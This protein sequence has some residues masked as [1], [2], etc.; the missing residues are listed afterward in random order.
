[1]FGTA[2]TQF[3]INH[4]GHYVR[5][6]SRAELAKY[7]FP[8]ESASRKILACYFAIPGGIGLGSFIAAI[9][10]PF[11]LYRCP[12]LLNRPAKCGSCSSTSTA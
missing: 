10:L 4:E 8:D 2:C 12:D 6:R 9:V 11:I 3:R 7:I 5:N 1:M